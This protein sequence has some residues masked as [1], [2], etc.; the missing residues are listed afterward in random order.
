M[1][2]P[3]TLFD[4]SDPLI[5]LTPTRAGTRNL[6]CLPFAGGGSSAFNRWSEGIDPSVKIWAARP[7]G[8][9]SRLLEPP[10]RE[11][12]AVVEALLPAA[13]RLTDRPYVVFG[14]S[15]GAVLGYELV[16]ALVASGRPQPALLV[17]SGRDAAH[18]AEL[19][20]RPLYTLPEAEL[21]EELRNYGA[22]P[23]P[24]LRD[25]EL[26]ALFLPT[27]RADFEVAETYHHLP[28]PRLSCPMLVLRGTEDHEV[29]EAGSLA[30]GELTTGRSVLRAIDGGHFFIDDA[31]AETLAVISEEIDRC[32]PV[33]RSS[34]A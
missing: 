21:I 11:F 29:T 23:E 30:W 19:P 20:H 9:E 31:R 7:A 25:P 13:L 33:Y 2:V 26:L 34:A 15:M 14:H 1:S 24:L 3:G 6:L 22:T 28:G 10:L 18:L 27:I 16:R 32:L 8:R 4:P 17:V 5:D 12:G